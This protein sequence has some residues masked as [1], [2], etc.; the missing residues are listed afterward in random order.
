MALLHRRKSPRAT[1]SIIKASLLS[2]A[3]LPHYIILF[4][5]T[6]QGIRNVKDT[7]KRAENYKAAVEDAGGRVIKEYYTFGKHDIV[8]IVEAPN[9][10][11]IMSV[12]LSTGKLGNTRSETLK[13]FPLSQ[14]A[15]IIEKLS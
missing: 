8:T 9:D 3:A 15:E 11:A 12:L 6:D 13:A 4:N 7:I 5:F 10:E 1:K 2:L 14:A